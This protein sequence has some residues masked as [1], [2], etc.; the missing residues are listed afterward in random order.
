MN[1]Y[2]DVTIPLKTGQM[3]YPTDSPCEIK[4]NS[5]KTKISIL[6]R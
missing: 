4:I 5:K 3:V 2:I 6:T 1:D